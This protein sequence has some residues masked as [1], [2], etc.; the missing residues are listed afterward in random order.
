MG[1]KSN[2]TLNIQFSIFSPA[3]RFHG[4]A[5]HVH[6]LR[7]GGLSIVMPVEKI[8]GYS[9]IVVGPVL[10]GIVTAPREYG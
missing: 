2:S 10:I 1:G 9:N 8:Q 3:R 5:R 6:V 7:H 4:Q